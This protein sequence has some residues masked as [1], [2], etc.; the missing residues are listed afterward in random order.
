MSTIPCMRLHPPLVHINFPPILSTKPAIILSRKVQLAMSSSSSRRGRWCALD[1][2]SELEFPRQLPLSSGHNII[3]LLSC[4]RSGRESLRRTWPGLVRLVCGDSSRSSLPFGFS[5]TSRSSTQHRQGDY[6]GELALLN[7]DVRQA[8]V[9]ALNSTVCQTLDRATF[10]RVVGPLEVGP[11]FNFYPT[12]LQIN[13]LFCLRV[14][15][16][17]SPY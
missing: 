6:F 4:K 8:S 13:L 7:D 15:L 11:G 9:R 12:S 2:V 1:Q 3:P 5:L 17:P 10:K 14:I 16:E